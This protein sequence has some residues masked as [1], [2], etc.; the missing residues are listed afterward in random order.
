M[1][2]LTNYVEGLVTLAKNGKFGVKAVDKCP[3][4]MYPL[5]DLRYRLHSF[6]SHEGLGLD[7]WVRLFGPVLSQKLIPL[8]Y[9]AALEGRIDKMERLLTKERVAMRVRNSFTDL[10]PGIDFAEQLENENDIE[11]LLRQQVEILPRNDGDLVDGLNKLKLNPGNQRFYGKSSGVQFVQTVFS[12]QAHLAGVEFSQM[13]RTA[14]S[15]KRNEFWELSPWQLPPP[16]EDIPQY[17]FPEPD[18]LLDLVDKYFAEV[19]PFWPVLHRPVFERKVADELHLRDHR[20]GGT[21]LMV[22]ALGARYSDD[23][24]VLLPDHTLHYA[25]WKWHSQWDSVYDE[26][27]TSV[28]IVEGSR[29][30]R[31]R[32]MNNGTSVLGSA[33]LRVGVWHAHGAS[34]DYAR[35]R[36]RPSSLCFVEPTSPT[37]FD[38]ELPVECDD[39][40]WDLPGP[41]NFKQP[42]DKPSRLS[43]FIC[44][45]KLLEIQ[46]AVTTTLRSDYHKYSPRK[47]H[48]LGGRSS[49]PTDTQ[50]IM[51]FDSALNAWLNDIPEHLRWDPERPNILH[52]KQSP[53]FTQVFKYVHRPFIPAPFEFPRQVR[54]PPVQS[55][56]MPQTPVAFVAGIVLLLCSW[57]GKKSSSKELDQVHSC[58]KLTGDAENRFLVAGRYTYYVSSSAFGIL[59]DVPSSDMINRL[60]YASGSRCINRLFCENKSFPP[61]PPS[62]QRGYETSVSTQR[63]GNDLDGTFSQ[64]AQMYQTEFPMNMDM[65]LFPGNTV[66]DSDV[67]ALWSAAPSDF[68]VDEWSY[69][70]PED[71]S[72]PRFEQFSNAAVETA[73]PGQMYLN[74]NGAVLWNIY[75]EDRREHGKGLSSGYINEAN[76]NVPRNS[77]WFSIDIPDLGGKAIFITGG[78]DSPEEVFPLTSFWIPPASRRSPN[79]LANKLRYLYSNSP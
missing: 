1:A 38:Q 56:A 18:L 7:E 32:K 68:N 63:L 6:G 2:H 23:P 79:N 65:P 51:A 53:F 73:M 3:E 50:C 37:S 20:F 40:Y 52:F 75:D 42:K 71:M 46:A 21:L 70:I 60:L 67:M 17:S 16:D 22:A 27:R 77:Q 57:S 66:A 31:Q 34:S 8:R 4:P 26:P 72:G 43:Y 36:V 10:L 29:S 69:V 49:P 59:I 15:L 78:V 76:L 19:N 35:P 44:Y 48:D 47:P 14:T 62:A 24:R 13:R 9:V 33:L 30:T 55:V 28:P 5:Y 54:F 41:R 11:P 61:L 39:E 58:L 25:G 64:L 74:P 45:A 12:F